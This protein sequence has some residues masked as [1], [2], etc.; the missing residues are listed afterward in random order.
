MNTEIDTDTDSFYTEYNSDSDIDTD[1]D[2]DWLDVQNRISNVDK[3]FSKENMTF[4]KIHY[5][6]IDLSSNLEEIKTE[7]IELSLIDNEDD[8]RT[9]PQDELIKMI[10]TKKLNPNKKKYRFLEMLLYN[11]EVEPDNI[12]SYSQDLSLDTPQKYLKPLTILNGIKISP[13]LF[14]FHQINCIYFLYQEVSSTPI[15]KTKT[16]KVLFKLQKFP[17]SKTQKLREKI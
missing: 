14:V 5:I 6:Y 1:L 13:T 3:R 8:F 12:Q 9:I 11:V 16:K 10:Y 17:T 7:K 4:I 15:L 2:L